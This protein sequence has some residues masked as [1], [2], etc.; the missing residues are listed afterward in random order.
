MQN[1]ARVLFVLF[2]SLRVVVWAERRNHDHAFCANVLAQHPVKIFQKFT[3]VVF[4]TP[5]GKYEL[6]NAQTLLNGKWVSFSKAISFPTPVPAIEQHLGE[7]VRILAQAHCGYQSRNPARKEDGYLLLETPKV[8]LRKTRFLESKPQTLLHFPVR[9]HAKLL[10]AFEAWLDAT[11]GKFSNV[12]AFQRAIWMGDL[13]SMPKQMARFYQEGGLLQILALSGQHVAGMVLIYG[14]IFQTLLRGLHITTQPHYFRLVVRF[15]PT[16]CVLTLFVT[17]GGSASIRRT[18]MMIVAMLLLRTRR[19]RAGPMQLALSSVGLL[20]AWDP[21]FLLSTGFLLSAVT[22]VF[23]VQLLERRE[24]RL[25][26]YMFLS[27]TMPLLVLPL[28]AF[29]FS[30][31]AWFSSMNQLLI[32]WIWEL[33]LIPLGFCLP[34]LVLLPETGALLFLRAFERGFNWFSEAHTI[35]APL[36]TMTYRTVVRP[37]LLELFV[38]E[39]CLLVAALEIARRIFPDSK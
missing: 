11:F 12:H 31:A 17:S 16:I 7:D 26:Y 13:T 9:M 29:F 35:W 21:A 24:R 23:L 2:V 28:T 1:I 6:R 27:F 3:G 38:V 10:A 32:G 4:K 18:S 33:F 14:H 19:L 30:K 37:N 34:L 5:S 25:E 36:N 22:T 15:L 39:F 8:S 20:I